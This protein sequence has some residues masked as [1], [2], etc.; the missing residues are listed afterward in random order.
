MSLAHY[1]IHQYDIRLQDFKY[2]VADPMMNNDP[3]PGK[4]AQLTPL[5][6]WMAL[7]DMGCSAAA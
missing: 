3:M 1:P 4:P 7:N 5:R 6:L 2:F